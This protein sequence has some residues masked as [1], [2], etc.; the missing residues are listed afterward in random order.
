MN[1]GAALPHTRK[2]LITANEHGRIRLPLFAGFICSG[3]PGQQSW[4]K[5]AQ[6]SKGSGWYGPTGKGT[7]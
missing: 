1:K 7:C 4:R 3:A 5:A 2:E 6:V